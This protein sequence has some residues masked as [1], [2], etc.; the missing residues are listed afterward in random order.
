MKKFSFLFLI[1]FLFLVGCAAPLKAPPEKDS[2]AKSFV[3]LRNKS[4]LYVFRNEN[5]GGAV[6]MPISINGTGIGE[7]AAKTFFR[8]DLEPGYYLVTSSAENTSELALTLIEGRNHF[9][10]QEVRMG[11]WKARTA[12]SQVDEK[13]GRDGVLESVL[14]TPSASEEMLSATRMNKK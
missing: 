4:S 10:W 6:G 8:L 3:P 12:L 5:Y 7:T 14:L 2:A 1:S 9:V 11:V 13:K